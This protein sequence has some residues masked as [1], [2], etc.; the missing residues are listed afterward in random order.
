MVVVVLVD[1]IIVVLVEI[2]V[3]DAIVP[4]ALVVVESRRGSRRGVPGARLLDNSPNFEKA[5]F[6]IVTNTVCSAPNQ[7]ITKNTDTGSSLTVCS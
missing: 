4:V 3:G 2:V 6:K 5:S 7:F 1:I